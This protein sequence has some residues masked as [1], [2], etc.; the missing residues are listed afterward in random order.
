MKLSTHLIWAVAALIGL[1]IVANVT[2][3]DDDD[4]DNGKG[5][6]GYEIV[7]VVED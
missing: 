6:A 4:D 2:T 5:L 1:G 3:A 7:V